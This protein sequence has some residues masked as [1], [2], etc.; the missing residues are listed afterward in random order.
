MVHL[1]SEYNLFVL[2]TNGGKTPKFWIFYV[3]DKMLY[4]VIFT[5]SSLLESNE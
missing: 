2:T 4:I 1:L 5:L 3:F